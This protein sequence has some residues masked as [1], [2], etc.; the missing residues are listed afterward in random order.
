MIQFL[1]AVPDNPLLLNGILAGLL[2]SVACGVMGPYVVTRRIVFLTGAIAHTTLGGIG[3]A[4]LLQYM[5][6]REGVI[7]PFEEPPFWASPL[8]GAILAAV[9]SAVVIGIVHD[10]VKERMD[11]L[12]GAMWAVGMSL[13]VMLIKFTPTS[14]VDPMS[15]LF[16]NIAIVGTDQLYLLA[17]LNAVILVTVAIFHKQL[18]SICVDEQQTHLQGVNVLGM[19]ILL[20]VLVALA[21]VS[22]IQIVGLILVLALLSLPAATASHHVTRMPAMMGLSIL[23]CA[24]LTT[25]PRMAVY[26]IERM[27][28]ESAIVLA[29]AAVYLVSVT[30]VRLRQRWRRPAPPPAPA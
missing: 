19:H 2:A 24:A 22:L 11:T 9:A 6:R 29:S 21:V 12:I 8:V 23:L 15:Y 1:Q 5:L 10:R 25:L 3:G 18:L 20:L 7:Q 4:I 28:P 26:P 13:G 16:G 27:S 30:A 17:G 14:V